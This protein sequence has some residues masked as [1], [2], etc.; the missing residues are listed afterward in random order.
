MSAQRFASGKQIVWRGTVFEIKRLLPGSQVSLENILS[1]VIVTADIRELVA[2][3]YK[4]EMVFVQEGKHVKRQPPG[5]ASLE[6]KYVDPSDCPDHL[7]EVARFRWWVIEPLL[8]LRPR[9]RQ[10]VAERAK[11]ADQV[12]GARLDGWTGVRAVSAASIYRWIDDYEQSGRDI[13]ALIPSYD[14]CGG[15]GKGRVEP[16]VEAIITSVIEDKYAKREKSTLDDIR[17]EV[18]ARI[19]DENKLRAAMDCLVHP[20]RSTIE[21]RIEALDIKQVFILKHGKRAAE[22]EFAQFGRGPEARAPLERVEIDHT[23]LDLVVI[24]RRDNLPLGRVTLTDC[25]DIATRYPL[26][27]YLG[28]EPPGYYAVMEC[29][30][31]AIRP[32]E[33]CKEQ[34]GTLHDWLAHGIPYTLVTDNGKEFIGKDL[35]DA[36][37]ALNIVLEQ[38][39]VRQPHYKGKIERLF[40]SVAVVVHG[41]PGTTFSNPGERGDY[42]SVGQACIYLDEVEAILNRFFVDIYAERKHRGLEGVPARRWEQALEA[43]F[44][45]RLPASSE[46]LLILLGKVDWRAV[47]A[48][49]IDFE[50]IRYNAPELTLLRHRLKEGEK[51]KLKFHPGDLSCIY[52]HDPFDGQYIAA[53]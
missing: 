22:R 19:S 28:F 11:E 1:G 3:L 47:H 25:M 40:G 12:L 15:R 49:G 8:D 10:V 2:D 43:G 14:A 34:H 52:V 35:E 33:K 23:P 24:D 9:T 38:S 44:L 4:G 36:C 27:Y 48:Y 50:C 7:L 51:A 45:P 30:Y 26:G 6:V 42:D 41:L 13:R 16:E 53:R 18:A 32:K 20:A 39:P 46:E 29:L 31:H 17:H 21:R 5:R 37:L